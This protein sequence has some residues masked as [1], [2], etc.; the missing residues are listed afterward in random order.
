MVDLVEAPSAGDDEV[1]RA[2]ARLSRAGKRPSVEAVLHAVCLSTGQATVVGHT[3]P[4]AVNVVLCSAH[5]ERL[6][7]EVVFPD[8]VVV[9]GSRPVLVPYHDPGL[10]LARAVKRGIEAH[11]AEEGKAP[12]LTT[13]ATTGS[14]HW[15]GRPPMCSR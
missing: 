11:L 6:A 15:A 12:R 13:S 10:E 3:H 9:L 4:V 2:F 8:Q 7:S 5:A 14:W 1:D